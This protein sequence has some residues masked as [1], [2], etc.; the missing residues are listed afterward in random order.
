[1]PMPEDG[2]NEEAPR[3]P[4]CDGEGA[5]LGLMG[6]LEWWRCRHCGIDFSTIGITEGTEDQ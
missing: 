5:F 6:I 2:S 3:C 1:M 4:Q